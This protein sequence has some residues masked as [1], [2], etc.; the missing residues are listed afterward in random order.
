MY[1]LDNY[2]SK[3]GFA[4]SSLMIKWRLLDEHLLDKKLLNN[5]NIFINF[6][7]ILYNLTLQ[8][9]LNESIAYHKKSVILDLESSI[10]NL[11]A[12]YRK[13]FMR[14]QTNPKI[15]LY[16]TSFNS[17]FQEMKIYNKHYRNYY[18]N[19]YIQNP[20]FSNMGKLINDIIIPEIKLITSY[21]PN[22]YFIESSTFDSSLIPYIISTFDNNSSN[23]IISS[24][25]FDTLYFNNPNFI[26][27]YIKRR[28][29]NLK[30]I[31]TIEECVRSILKDESPF[32][33]NIFNGELY[34]RLLLS[35]K[36]SKIRN[37]SSAKGFGYTKLVN[38]LK[39][40]LDNDIVLKDFESIESII[41]LFPSKYQDDIR[42]SFKC[43][44]LETQYS[45]INDADI[46]NIKDQLIDKRDIESIEA[47]N[48]KRFLEFPININGLIY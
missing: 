36:G 46:N 11:I 43:T 44:S 29:T 19:R 40:G 3:I 18:S 1:Q 38:I 25:I 34:Y 6:E 45:L 39:D 30:I 7:T 15:Y 14:L 41:K 20:S 9:N 33:I 5:S 42:L 35:I 48:N 17:E 10:L 4:A 37:I 12:N 23:I 27:I 24:D 16:T 22:C 32:D 28:F 26:V 21:I 31:S 13:Y 8:K 47:L 2:K